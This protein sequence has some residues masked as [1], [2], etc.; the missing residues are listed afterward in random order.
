MFLSPGGPQNQLHNL[1]AEADRLQLEVNLAKTC[2]V[3]FRKE[4][5]CLDTKY[6]LMGD[7]V[8][9][10]NSY[11]YLGIALTTKLSTTQAVAEFTP[12]A[13]QNIV[14]IFK[15]LRT[16]KCSD[17]GVFSKIFDAQIQPALL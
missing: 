9:A 11:K 15:A 13:E 1:K 14:T 7:L 6:G 17:W 16:T 2:M 10:V 4:D 5:T 12:K 3:V 8:E